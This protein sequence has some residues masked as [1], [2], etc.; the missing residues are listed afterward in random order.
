M[1]SEKRCT[2]GA[3]GDGKGR[4]PVSTSRGSDAVTTFDRAVDFIWAP[5][6]DGH[7]NDRAPGESFATAWGI[8]Q[9]TWDDAVAS[10]IVSGPLADATPAQCKAIYRADYWDALHCPALNPGVAFVL[11]NDATLSGGDAAAQLLQRVVGATEDGVIG[12]QTLRLAN[13]MSPTELIERLTVADE[14]YL[15]ALRN[16]P[17]FIRGWDRREQACQAEALTLVA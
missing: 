17:L 2:C 15:A 11:F 10:G 3:T 8:T 6:R 1:S 9:M 13:A 12:P 14:K 7:R 4:Q 16:A 5:S